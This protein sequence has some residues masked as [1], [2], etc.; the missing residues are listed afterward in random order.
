[1][2]QLSENNSS[3]AFTN[4]DSWTYNS[5]TNATPVESLPDITI[6]I[7]Y[8]FIIIIPIQSCIGIPGNLLVITAVLTN[9][10]LRVLQ[11]VFIVNLAVADLIITSLVN[12]FAIAGALSNLNENLFY[13]LPGLCEFLASASIISAVCSI[14][15]ICSI[16]LNRYC[17]I[18]HRFVYPKIYNTCTIPFIIIALWMIAIMLDFPNFVGLNDHIYNTHIF[19]CRIE[20][21]DSYDISYTGDLFVFGFIIPVSILCYSYLRIYLITRASSRRIRKHL[22]TR[23]SANLV[24]TRD[25]RLLKTVAIICMTF[26]ILWTPFFILTFNI[27]HKSWSFLIPPILAST[28]SS[29]NVFIYAKNEN[30]RQ[31][32]LDIRTRLLGSECRLASIC[33]KRPPHRGA[34]IHEMDVND[35]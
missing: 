24:D 17:Y 30:F 1:M 25:R 29:V 13:R 6:I 28:N 9:K 10:K 32:Y 18:C 34:E 15:S 14:W 16:A 11:N 8:A 2:E 7:I 21:H 20:N 12:P 33:S 19:F 31:A 5:T 27:D 26:L 23:T 3:T 4:S 35:K 22:N